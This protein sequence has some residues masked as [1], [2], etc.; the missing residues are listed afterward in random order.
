MKPKDAQK[1]A[2][3][4]KFMIVHLG[5][6][7]IDIDVIVVHAPHSWETKHQEGA[8]EQTSVFW[9]QFGAALTR[10]A[11][12]HVPLFILGDANLELSLAQACYEAY[13]S[14]SLLKRP[15]IMQ[16]SFVHFWRTT[17]WHCHAHTETST[18]ASATLSRRP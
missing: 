1:V 7:W 3:G 10:R 17:N 16:A 4:P 12:P 15:P 18:K 14:T 11:K 8:E 9:E 6:K 5:N 13:D 2:T